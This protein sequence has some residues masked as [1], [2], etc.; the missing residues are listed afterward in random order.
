MSLVHSAKIN[1]HDPYAYLKDVLQRLPTHAAGRIEEL[2]PCSGVGLEK[3]RERAAASC[4][5]RFGMSLQRPA[6][7]RSEANF[8]EMLARARNN[9]GELNCGGMR[10]PRVHGVI[11]EQSC[12]HHGNIGRRHV[13]KPTFDRTPTA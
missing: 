11:T 10:H 3:R 4:R 2:L 8:A 1:G 6:S 5:A 7:R 13:R 9:P 12:V